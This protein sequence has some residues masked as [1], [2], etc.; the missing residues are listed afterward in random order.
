MYIKGRG[1]D[2]SSPQIEWTVESL[3]R[4]LGHELGHYLGVYHSVE[5]DGSP[6]ALSDTDADNLMYARPSAIDAP[7]F[8]NHQFRI[9][10]QHPAI[11]WQ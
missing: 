5:L 8:T 11:A 1:C 2:A 10:R 3:A 9:M 4:V 6:D 7:H